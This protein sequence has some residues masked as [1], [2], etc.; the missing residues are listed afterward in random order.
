MDPRRVPGRRPLRADRRRARP[1][2]RSA[3][4]APLELSVDPAARPRGLDRRGHL[5]GAVRRP[6]VDRPQRPAGADARQLGARQQGRPGRAGPQG[7]RRRG[8]HRLGP[9]R[10]RPGHRRRG[11]P[12]LRH[13][14]AAR[15]RRTRWSRRRSPTPSGSWSSSRSCSCCSRSR[16]SSRSAAT[17]RSSASATGPDDG[18]AY[19]ED[20]G[21]EV[22]ELGDVDDLDVHEYGDE[23]AIRRDD[24]PVRATTPTSCDRRGPDDDEPRTPT[25]RRADEPRTPT[26]SRTDEAD[27]EPRGAGRRARRDDGRRRR[28][29]APTTEAGARPD[30]RR[31]RALEPT[32]VEPATRPGTTRRPSRRRPVDEPTRAAVQRRGRAPLTGAERAQL[33]PAALRSRRS[34]LGSAKISDS[35]AVCTAWASG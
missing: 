10:R 18:P 30:E 35:S 14:A 2:T 17:G 3:L 11:Q 19:V 9:A 23:P 1:P 8:R 33:R 6:R 21:Y 16:S 7:R 27:D 22:D 32:T 13:R 34:S 31:G 5:A 12:R 15:W 4:D 20:E 28:R 25:S 26:T 29:R 24:D